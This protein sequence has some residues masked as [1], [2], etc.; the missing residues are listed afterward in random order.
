MRDGRGR[1]VSILIEKAGEALVVEDVGGRG[2]LD[3]ELG[4]GGVRKALIGRG[5]A[6]DQELWGAEG[7]ERFG[8]RE[9]LVKEEADGEEAGARIAHGL[10]RGGRRGV[11][12]G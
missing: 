7:G 10:R 8:E 3:G 12:R 11:S 2:E 1:A 4:I 9:A 6:G 5:G